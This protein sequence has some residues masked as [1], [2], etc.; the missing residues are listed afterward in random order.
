MRQNC[1]PRSVLSSKLKRS[2]ILI[3][4]W[5]AYL[6]DR[7]RSRHKHKHTSTRVTA[8][9]KTARLGLSRAL[10]GLPSID[11]RPRNRHWN[12]LTSWARPRFKSIPYGMRTRIPR[13]DP[14]K[15]SVSGKM[16]SIFFV[17]LKL[18]VTILIRKLNFANTIEQIL[19]QFSPLHILF[20]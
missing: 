15:W 6:S 10:Q 20:L 3:G 2:A 17:L 14:F 5:R 13:Q 7:W 9:I 1:W 18:H 16:K 19:S 11:R 8:Q 12:V 4:D